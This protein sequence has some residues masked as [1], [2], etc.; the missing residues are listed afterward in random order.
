M[1]WRCSR[2]LP[3]GFGAPFPHL[4]GAGEDDNPNLSITKHRKLLCLLQEATSSFGEGHLPCGG[5]LDP[6]YLNLSTS[7]LSSH[8]HKPYIKE[9]MF[10]RRWEW[11]REIK[12]GGRKCWIFNNFWY[13][14]KLSFF[15]ELIRPRAWEIY[16]IIL[17]SSINIYQEIWKQFLR[18]NNECPKLPQCLFVFGMK[19]VEREKG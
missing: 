4:P 2:H 13:L 18:A 8:I 10:I 17:V 19:N 1:E 15:V 16:I 6:L 3:E 5:V 11:S 12:G 7:H 14:G 9:K